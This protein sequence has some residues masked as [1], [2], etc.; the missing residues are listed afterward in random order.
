MRY[1]RK[2]KI[3]STKTEIHDLPEL[4]ALDDAYSGV[5][6]AAQSLIANLT[7]SQA[8]WRPHPTAWSV[9]ECLDHLAATN[10]IYLTAMQP[11][12]AAA[13]RHDKLRRRSA[14]PGYFGAW[15]V[16]SLEPPVKLKSPSPSKIKPRIAPALADASA[17][18]FASHAAAH[19]F[20]RANADLDL[21]SIR[22]RNP[23]VKLLRLTLATAFHI[24]PA[25]E[26]RHLYQAHAVL[27]ASQ[28]KPT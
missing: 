21:A 28:T 10:R 22:F 15:F 24:I 2:H 16:R 4:K 19:N 1:G 11:A 8:A 26:R 27:A 25:H 6:T 17:A 23:F 14:L 13:R 12:V 9:S 3:M 18:F 7:E 20:L 5:H